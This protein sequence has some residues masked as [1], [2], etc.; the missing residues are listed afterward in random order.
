MFPAEPPPSPKSG[1]FHFIFWFF[2]NSS[3]Y[4][5][6]V[7]YVDQSFFLFQ[8]IRRELR[9]QERQ[10]ARSRDQK[11]SSI[12]SWGT[13]SRVIIIIITISCVSDQQKQQEWRDISWQPGL[14]RGGGW[15]LCCWNQADGSTAG[16]NRRRYLIKYSFDS[17]CK[18]LEVWHQQKRLRMYIYTGLSVALKATAWKLT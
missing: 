15:Y 11:S 13:H 18:W 8:K 4:L 3:L 5:S 9:A 7:L 14:G 10:V 12:P 17:F 16:S 6:L 1:K 2:F